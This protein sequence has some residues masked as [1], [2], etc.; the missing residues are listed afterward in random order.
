MT[1][2][3]RFPWLTTALGVATLAAWTVPGAADV[4]AF[5]RDAL[6]AGA[7]WR[8]VTGHFVHWT[9]NHL[10]WDLGAFL[11]L[12]GLIERRSRR[13]FGLTLVSAA[14]AISA[15][16]WLFAPQL[17]TYR[18]L[19][20][21]DTAL[22]AAIV[23]R[24]GCESFARRAWLST[25]ISTLAVMAFVVKTT[26]ECVGQQPLFVAADATFV[27]V[28]LAHIVGACVGTAVACG[29]T[30]RESKGSEETLPRLEAMGGS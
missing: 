30:W 3:A 16:V 13:E 23:A 15:G 29:L 6:A 7:W 10:V 9:T 5:D 12:G 14:A 17:E 24:A 1:S 25:A 26:V 4:L 21:L 18:G 2:T 19:S 20:G 11:V 27:S 22:F 8:V 28:P